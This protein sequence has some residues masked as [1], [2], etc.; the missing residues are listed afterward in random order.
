MTWSDHYR[1]YARYNRWM[2][3]QLLDATQT[4]PG[5]VVAAPTGL[6][7]GS[8][9]GSW[10][11]LLVADLIWLRRLSDIFPILDELRRLPQPEALNQIIYHD[12]NNLRPV[13]EQIDDL[14]IRWCDLLRADDA[15][16]IVEYINSRGEEIVRPL[17]LI[18]QHLFNHQ[19]HHRGQITAGLSAQGVDYGI[20]DLLYMP[21]AI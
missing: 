20:T 7:F 10:N 1:R 6:F 9:L 14:I 21:D 8:L 16:D 11:H 3:Q 18:L 17:Y 13:R 12:L 15:S 5:D 19:T 4:L 2:N